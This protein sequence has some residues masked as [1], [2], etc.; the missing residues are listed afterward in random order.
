M[1]NYDLGIICLTCGASPNLDAP[2]KIDEWDDAGHEDSAH[3]PNWSIKSFKGSEWLAHPNGALWWT[4]VVYEDASG[5]T[6]YNDGYADCEDYPDPL[7][8]VP[9]SCK[10]L[11][12]IVKRNQAHPEHTGNPNDDVMEVWTA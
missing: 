2:R 1:S 3:R 10:P 11:E 4:E 9:Q 6:D 12:W 5:E 8:L 7:L